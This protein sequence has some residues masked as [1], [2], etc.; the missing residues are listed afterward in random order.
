MRAKKS[1]TFFLHLCSSHV[2]FLQY[3]SPPPTIFVLHFLHSLSLTPLPTYTLTSP[4]IIIFIFFY[5][6]PLSSDPLD[7]FTHQ[8][9]SS[10]LHGTNTSSR[11]ASRRESLVT[12]IWCRCYLIVVWIY[13]V[14]IFYI[15]DC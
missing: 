12:E 8:S 10:S 15:T 4:S 6:T 5:F 2:P 13:V 9:S 3:T 7:P 14:E 1:M 11:T